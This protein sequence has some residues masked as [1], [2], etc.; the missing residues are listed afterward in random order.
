MAGAEGLTDS[1]RIPLERQEGQEIAVSS[2]HL[3][4]TPVQSLQ[5]PR[6]TTTS[7]HRL[8][9]TSTRASKSGGRGRSHTT[10]G[11]SIPRPSSG[12]SLGPKMSG[13]IF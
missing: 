9:P 1:P 8:N 6:A 10:G 4:E 3:Q 13:T 12:S 2:P 5:G 11:R 7:G